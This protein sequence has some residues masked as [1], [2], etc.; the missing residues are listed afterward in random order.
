MPQKLKSWLFTLLKIAIAVVGLWWVILH[1]PWNDQ[2]TLLQTQTQHGRTVEPIRTVAFRQNVEVAVLKQIYSF[3]AAVRD[4]RQQ[5]GL[6]PQQVADAARVTLGQLSEVENQDAPPADSSLLARLA[7]GL[8]IS[9]AELEQHWK[10]SPERLLIRFPNS[11][12]KMR[13]EDQR[14]V[15][16]VVNEQTVGLPREMEISKDRFAYVSAENPEIAVQVGLKNLVKR[17]NLSLLLL[18]WVVLVVPFIVTAWRWQKLMEPQGLFLPYRKC[19]ALTFV[20]QFYSTF[21]PGITG[22]DLVKIIYTSR[23]T[24]SKTKSTV[25][26][27][28]DRVIG[29]VALMVI[30]GVSA[31]LQAGASSTMRNVALLIGA[32]LAG[33]CVG[34]VV[35]FSHRLRRISGLGWFLNHEVMPEFVR[36]ADEVLHAY[37]GA[38]RILCG[39]FLAS[40]VAQITLPLSAWLAGMAFGMHQANIGHFLAYTPLATLAASVPIAPPAGFGIIEWVLFH[41]FASKSLATPSQTFALA[42]AI[43]FLPIFWN[44]VGAYWV[45]TGSY[46][47][48][49]SAEPEPQLS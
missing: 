35:Y 45:V 3:G 22:G 19:L 48:Q 10:E 49:P 11:N 9:A 7:Q 37:R 27:M 13:L 23:V 1:T 28:L 14:D 29:L 33:L 43:R 20:G 47:R 8:K 5:K 46:S 44:L 4:L 38:W 2:A 31:M 25:T 39:A 15:D 18:A 16:E 32:I 24:G 21:L 17:A 42:Q 6:S 36:K 30:A 34:A 40:L 41:F 26:I 12:I